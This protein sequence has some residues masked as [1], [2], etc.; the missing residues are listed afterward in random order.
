MKLRH[1]HFTNLTPYVT[2]SRI[3]DTLVSRLLAYKAAQPSSLQL[4]QP[5]ATILT[6]QFAPTYTAGLRSID[7]LSEGEIAH[8]RANGKAHFTYAPRG[9]QTTFHGPG[10]L[11]AYPILDLRR[12]SLTARCYVDRLERAAIETC[13]AYGVTARTTD[14]VGVWV[15]GIDG[16]ERKICAVG[17]HLRRHVSS[18]GIGLNVSTDMS[19]FERIVACGLEGKETTSFLKEGVDRLSIDAVGK[20]FVEKLASRL[21]GIDE[22]EYIEQTPE[23]VMESKVS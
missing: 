15:R 19:W 23:D 7:R 8:L 4:Q 2:G 18:H 5:P 20:V 22:I 12:H 11:V 16:E 3:Q 9:G 6:F 13:A 14:D 10:Q 21:T 1:I 17:V